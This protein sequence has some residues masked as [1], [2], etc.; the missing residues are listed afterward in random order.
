MER[1]ANEV[2]GRHEIPPELCPDQVRKYEFGERLVVGAIAGYELPPL[3]LEP[4]PYFGD[5]ELID[6]SKQVSPKPT[7]V[8]D[9]ETY[10]NYFLIAFRC[11]HSG[12][13]VT[14]EL[15]PDQP[16]LDTV[17]L[18]WV[19][20]NFRLVGFNSWA[21]DEPMLWAAIAGLWNCELYQLSNQIINQDRYTRS[22]AETEWKFA[23][24]DCDHVDL[25]S[26]APS[27]ASFCSLKQYGGRMN[28]QRMQDLPYAPT[29]KLTRIEAEHVKQYCI[30]GDLTTTAMLLQKLAKPIALRAEMSMAFGVDLR[31][32][33]DAQISER[34]IAAEI[35][36]AT[37]VRPRRP[38][39]RTGELIKYNMPQYLEFASP[40][41]KDLYNRVW[42]A[43]FM[44]NDKGKPEEPEDLKG[45]IVTV[46]KSSYK[47]GIG[48]LH[49]QEKQQAVWSDNTY[50]LIDRDVAS[51]YPEII[52]NQKLYPQHIGPE[53]CPI[54]GKL[55]D[56]RLLA[57]RDGDKSTADSLKIAV[58]G[59][60][61][62]HGSPWS[63]LYSPETLLQ[64]TITGQ[65]T[66]LML[67]DMLE[68]HGI[69]V[70]SANT[71]GIVFRPK[72]TQADIVSR[73]VRAWEVRTGFTTEETRYRALCSR[74][75]NSYI[76]I[77]EDGK[78]KAKGALVCRMSM[79]EE[80]R[81]S[82]MKNPKFEICN[83]AVMRYLRDGTPIDKTIYNCKDPSKFVC[84]QRVKGGAVKNQHYLG[85]TVR[86]YI[87][88]NEFG[89]LKYMTSGNTVP[90]STGGYPLMRM[91]AMP[92][93]I[94]DGWYI[95]RSMKILKEIGVTS[96]NEKQMVMF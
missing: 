32:R 72:K 55:I 86:W 26:V 37:G 5:Q 24:G 40:E 81:E 43:E 25:Q 11:Y 60:F 46:G 53:Y 12:K 58:N 19:A 61:G 21:Y 69:P 47:F 23:I 28:V 50:D 80:N 36:E 65:L 9:I 89:D 77:T 93:D 88:R 66:L 22:N 90:D 13:V 44:I 51:Y 3:T 29:K 85:K 92:K 95:A 27:Q 48:G 70:M 52:R 76:A 39:R 8:F 35:Y 31:S 14:F 34:I 71:D 33:S 67:I 91:D 87:K 7:L 20:E 83:E 57:K 45:K 49:S 42:A 63:I 16:K 10:P 2:M 56:R 96:K 84:V 30:H 68:Y 62:K 74:D 59:G 15:S 78:I 54:Y 17:K 38:K 64:V 4:I 82:L 1:L 79:K 94:D 18:K 73:L 6:L 75:V 41:L